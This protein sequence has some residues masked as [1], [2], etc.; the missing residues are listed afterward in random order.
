MRRRFILNL[1]AAAQPRKLWHLFSAGRLA[2]GSTGG[3]LG[4]RTTAQPYRCTTFMARNSTR[5]LEMP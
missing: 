4:L 1:R 3:E 5:R 2:R